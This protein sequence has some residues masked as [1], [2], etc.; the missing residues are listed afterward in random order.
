[1]E[2][3]SVRTR[4]SG[5]KA[6]VSMWTHERSGQQKAFGKQQKTHRFTRNRSEWKKMRSLISI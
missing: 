1:M 5:T 3:L 4:R 2:S 6:G